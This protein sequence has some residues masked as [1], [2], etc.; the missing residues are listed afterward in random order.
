MLLLGDFVEQLVVDVFTVYLLGWR[1][2]ALLA[3][4]LRVLT[5]VNRIEELGWAGPGWD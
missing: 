4:L 1:V 2:D 5:Y 3:W